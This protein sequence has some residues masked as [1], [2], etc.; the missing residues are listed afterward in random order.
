MLTV[1]KATKTK[2]LLHLKKTLN[3]FKS[4]NLSMLF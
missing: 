3:T 2:S 4:V 1:Y